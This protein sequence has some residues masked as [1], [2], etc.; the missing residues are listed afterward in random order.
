MLDTM[1]GAYTRNSNCAICGQFLTAARR[2]NQAQNDFIPNIEL[3]QSLAF[4]CQHCGAWVC[5]HCAQAR[6]CQQCGAEQF[7]LIVH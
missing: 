3:K 4:Q 7:D 1:T 2:Q 5:W 6:R